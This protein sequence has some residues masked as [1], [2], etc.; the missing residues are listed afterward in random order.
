ML[1]RPGHRSI[2]Q[3]VRNI[4]IPQRGSF[5]PVPS[6]RIQGIDPRKPL[7]ITHSL[8]LSKNGKSNGWGR[9]GVRFWLRARREVRVRLSV[10]ILF[11]RALQ[12]VDP[13]GLVLN[14]IFVFNLC[15]GGGGGEKEQVNL[16]ERTDFHL[17]GENDVNV[18]KNRRL[19]KNSNYTQN[20]RLTICQKTH[21]RA[22][23]KNTLF[24]HDVCLFVFKFGGGG[25]AGRAR[26][27]CGII[28]YQYLMHT[29]CYRQ[30]RN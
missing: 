3:G 9:S 8:S 10:A 13:L 24:N 16:T 25:G 7:N 5:G 29:L 12:Q 2:H 27:S 21:A 26:S 14:L 28:Q 1:Q 11:D 17:T 30:T 22:D 4:S 6:L 15:W 23:C 19:K 18:R 20:T